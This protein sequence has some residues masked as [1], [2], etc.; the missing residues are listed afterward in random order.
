[1]L[2]KEQVNQIRRTVKNRRL[3]SFNLESEAVDYISCAVE[4]AVE[5]GQ[6]FEAAL[7]EVMADIGSEEL[8]K[9]QKSTLIIRTPN[10]IDMLQ[11]YLKIAWRNFFKYR[12]N[13]AINLLGLV[14]GLSTSI[15]IGLYLKHEFSYD[16]TYP[17][18][19]RL[20]RVNNVTYSGQTPEHGEVVSLLLRDALVEEVPEIEL[21][22]SFEYPFYQKPMKWNDKVFFDYSFAAVNRDFFDMF[23]IEVV[24]GTVNALY[25]QTMGAFISTDLAQR[26][27]GDLN[28]IGQVIVVA[29]GDKNHEVLVR[30]LFKELPANT[31]FQENQWSR[32]DVLTSMETGRKMSPRQGHWNSISSTAYVK[33]VAGADEEEVVSKINAM[34]KTKQ[35]GNNWYDHYLQP[36][37][38]LHLNKRG[39]EIRSAGNLDQLYTFSI[40]AILILLI[41]C[42]NYVNITTAQASIRLK[43]VGIRKVIGARRK[44]FVWQ[45]LVE[46]ALISLF[47]MVLS[48]VLVNG[49]MPFLNSTYAL[50]L[51]FS[52]SADWAALMVFIVVMLGV[53]LLCGTYPG[54]YLSRLQPGSLLKSGGSV[55]LGGSTFRKVL[56][57]LQYATSITLI[58]ATLIITS[59]LRFMSQRDLGFDK[60]QVLYLNTGYDLTRKY[61]EALY[62]QLS[63][64]PG[65]LHAS[66]TGHTLGSGMTMANGI[67]VNE[68]KSEEAEMHYCLP[69]DY[70]FQQAL[71]IEMIEGRW[72]DES[73]ATD[74]QEGYIVNEAFVKHFG[75]E[76]PIGTKLARNE[77]WGT[78]VGVAKDFHSRSMRFSIEPLVIHMA[79]R[80]QFGYWNMVVRLA[81]GESAKTLEKIQGIWG[82]TIADYPLDYR[83]LDEEI[84][85]FYKED[86]YFAN[87][88]SM[89][90]ILAI[91]VSCLG[92]IGLVSF[93]TKRRSKEIG[94]RKVLGASVLKILKL[95]SLDM[96]KLISIGAVLAV[97]IGYFAMNRWLENF[98]YRTD[99]AWWVFAVALLL[100]VLISW[101][102]VSYISYR[103]ANANPVDS[104]RSE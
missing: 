11:N 64:E 55:N 100:T 101:L 26:V 93:S 73:F 65:V 3:R 90:S 56:V 86:R 98:E 81:P 38:D 74:R 75:L 39:Y 25:D 24:E 57:V 2:S 52:I 77:K 51:T 63:Q 41:A 68:M 48:I 33:L 83:F 60:E 84:D 61:G 16:S 69:V 32:F 5:S 14:L 82:S 97:P 54:F 103:A 44:Q 40:I 20:Y 15:V 43:E 76:E 71:G 7:R 35:G 36:I 34:L 28:P 58:I 59:Q 92:L 80:N 19:D 22:T 45:F 62:N 99:I 42:V 95:I 87:M 66:L 49:V 96:V 13:T 104:L 6:S 102:S 89:F 9:A 29:D 70:E 79:P 46:A 23:G 21:A 72:F 17:D 53:S 31:E 78:I 85:N 88:F 94:V 1:M 47:A 91:V 8:D 18:V 10:A 12:V 27:F 37:R 50:N 4:E 67:Q 30:G